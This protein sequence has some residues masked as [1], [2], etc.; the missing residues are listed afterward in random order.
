MFSY[1]QTRSPGPPRLAASFILMS[2]ME[3]SLLGLGVRSSLVNNGCTLVRSCNIPRS[4]HCG[5]AASSSSSHAASPLSDFTCAGHAYAGSHALYS[6]PQ[7]Q[8]AN[9]FIL[10]RGA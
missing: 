4:L 8:P 7:A 9:C 1:Y 10:E 2:H 5:P 6:K 3:R